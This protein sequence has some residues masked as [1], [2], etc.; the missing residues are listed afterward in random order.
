[1]QPISSLVLNDGY[2]DEPSGG[3]DLDILTIEELREAAG[4]SD[5]SQ[6]AELTV[7]GRAIGEIIANHCNARA[8]EGSVP[9]LLAQ[10]LVETFRI[11]VPAYSLVLAR[12]PVGEISHVIAGGTFTGEYVALKGHGVLRRPSTAL[13]SGTVEVA[14]VGGFEVIPDALKYA[15]KAL[16]QGIQTAQSAAEI[17]S[18]LRSVSAE[19]VGTVQFNTGSSSDTSQRPLVPLFIDNLLTPYKYRT[20]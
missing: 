16:L 3:F 5:D 4:V 11:S 18:A 17:S 20:A 7:L 15:A 19:G 2:S 10:A 6:D 13:W 9:T 1:M 14:Y 12:R 8:A